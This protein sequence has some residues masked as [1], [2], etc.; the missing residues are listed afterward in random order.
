MTDKACKHAKLIVTPHSGAELSAEPAV[1]GS[2]AA[3]HG[4]KLSVQCIAVSNFAHALNL[5]M[6]GQAVCTHDEVRPACPTTHA[7]LSSN[8]LEGN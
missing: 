2:I 6:V 7:S 3:S 8:R 4:A 5:V 1:A